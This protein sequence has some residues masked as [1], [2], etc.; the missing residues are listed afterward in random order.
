M[1]RDRP[2]P[3]IYAAWLH[4]LMRALAADE[5]GPTFEDYGRSRPGFIIAAL[6]RNRQWCDDVTTQ[7][8][9]SCAGRIAPAL[10][11]AL[12]EIAES[13]GKDIARW[14]WGALHKAAF[15]HS[16]FTHVHPPNRLPH[17]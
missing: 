3:L 4:Q 7:E 6:T 13:P 17:L 16:V 14:R 15:I 12:D 1:R 10:D 5:L 8:P 2:E 9:E 11:I